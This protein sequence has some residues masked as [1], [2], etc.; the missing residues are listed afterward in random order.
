MGY[1][2]SV[3]VIILCKVICGRCN[4]EMTYLEYCSKHCSKHYNLC[5]IV[6]EDKL[7]SKNV[8]LLNN[9]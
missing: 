2:Q 7:V 1:S 5:W 4:K 8:I 6:G 3:N 9:V